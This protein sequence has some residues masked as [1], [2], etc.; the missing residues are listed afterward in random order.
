MRHTVRPFVKE[1]KDRWSK[2]SKP[3]PQTIVDADKDS[4]KQP[5]LDVGDSAT[6]QNNHNEEYIAALSAADA[7]FGGSSSVAP[8]QVKASSSNAHVGRVLPSLIDVDG[9]P[10]VRLTEV[11]EKSA[12]GRKARKAKSSP[13][14][15]LRKP[16]L[17]SKS[18]GLRSSAEQAAAN[19]SPEISVVSPRR[20]EHRSIQKRWVLKTEF[21]A[22]QKWKR[23][24]RKAGHRP[25]LS[26]LGNN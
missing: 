13:S 24:L 8:I 2:S 14:T 21:K 15:R 16:S 11:D 7:V 5:F 22:G 10:T 12:R 26:G 23:R 19:L 18:E 20:R 3:H 4:S 9:A 25:A 6:S 1:F 17:P